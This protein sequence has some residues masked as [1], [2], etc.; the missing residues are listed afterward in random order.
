M[1]PT[2]LVVVA[3]GLRCSTACGIFLDQG[4]HMCLLNWQV[5]SE[6]LDPREV[7]RKCFL[8]GANFASPIPTGSVQYRLETFLVTTQW[9]LLASSKTEARDTARH[10]AMHG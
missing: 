4:L 5:D 1:R 8:T 3:H 6:P 2:G 10:A 7:P 9:V